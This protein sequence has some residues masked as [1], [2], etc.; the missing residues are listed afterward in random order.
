MSG[1]RLRGPTPRDVWTDT[2]L[3][4][5]R[6]VAIERFRVQRMAEPLEA[7]LDHF[8]V[9]QEMLEDL[10][11]LTV[12]LAQ[13]EEQAL[14]IL[15]DARLFEGVRYL[16]GPPLSADDLKTL[17]ESTLSRQALERDPAVAQRV[18]Q[19]IRVGLDRR[20]FPWV[21]EGREPEES[22][23]TAAIVASAA[24]IAMRRT[25]TARRNEG[26]REQEELVRA[27]LLAYGLR[28]V[29]I[30]GLHVRTLAQAPQRGQFC[31]EVRL[32]P[33]DKA[34]LVVGIWDGR[35][36]AIECKVSNSAINSVKRLN[37]EAVSK[38][39]SWLDDFG[40]LQVVP[41]AVLS[42]VYK[43]HNLL[44]AQE[45]GLAIYWAHRLDDLIDWIERTRT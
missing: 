16:T 41:A 10:L 33:H 40:T 27:A 3:N 13:L 1:E 9:V 11:E 8:D 31:R 26:K 7:Y 32:G 43:L 19:A 20:R 25:E 42:G 39:R 45:R 4:A 24:M 5:E 38:T 44:D 15:V 14:N 35:T 29:A 23:R 21:A 30:P 28:E 17:V 34:D 36:M 2:R 6:L 18:I 37:K 12:D 22:E